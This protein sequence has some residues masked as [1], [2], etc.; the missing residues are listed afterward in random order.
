MADMSETP[1][2]SFENVSFAYAADAPVLQ[3]VSFTVQPGELVALRGNNGSGKSTIAKLVDAMLY[4]DSGIVRVFGM[5]TDE[6]E[7]TFAIRRACGMVFQDPDDQLVSTLVHDEVAFGP[8]N[9]GVSAPEVESRVREALRAVGMEDAY[10]RDVNTLSG[11]QKQRIAIAGALA[12]HPKLLIL[13]EAT[14]MLDAHATEEMISLIER[15]RE[16]GMTI[17]LITHEEEVARAADRT[18]LIGQALEEDGAPV[19]LAPRPATGAPVVELRDASFTY[20][21][22]E[23]LALEKV[24]LSICAG[25]FVALTGPNGCGKSTLLKLLNGLLQPTQGVVSILG[26]TLSSKE[27]RNGAR[28]QVGLAFQHPERQLFESTVYDDVAFGPRSLGL[29]SAEVEERVRQALAQVGLPFDEVYARNPFTL[30]G[31]QQ[32]KVAVAGILAMRTP[33]VALDEP[34]AGLDARGKHELL[35]ALA[36]LNAQGTT[37]IMVTHDATEAEALGCRIIRME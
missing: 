27:D 32:R 14:S 3:D 35:S 26:K 29:G 21:E 19:R 20:H 13:D 10:E 37:I 5:R 31:G 9:L 25:E 36:A 12:M 17:L 16:N 7:N 4:P 22:E 24:S 18:I 2:I 11:G 8:R 15:L 34:C 30:S 6:H 33:I 1:A 28:R 23:P